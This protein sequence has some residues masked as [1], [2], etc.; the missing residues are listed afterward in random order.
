[1]DSSASKK[2]PRPNPDSVDTSASNKRPR[3]NSHSNLYP[4][5]SERI[6]YASASPMTK[7]RRVVEII[8]L[9]HPEAILR[10]ATRVLKKQGHENASKIVDRL[11][12]DPTNMAD[13]Q[14]FCKEA[15]KPKGKAPS[16]ISPAR[17]LHHK[18]EI[19]LSSRQ[20]DKTAA[21]GNPPSLGVI[22]WPPS[23]QL[24][25]ESKDL[26]PE[27]IHKAYL[28]RYIMILTLKFIVT[29]LCLD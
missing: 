20:Y 1:M 2:R 6:D 27:V 3:S 16:V 19:G 23:N 14:S 18:L 4:A 21:L 7:D 22:I 10:A 28:C 25:D 9:Y 29:F 11:Q 17:A 8:E 12:K 24:K 26:R 5:K 15:Q 13:I